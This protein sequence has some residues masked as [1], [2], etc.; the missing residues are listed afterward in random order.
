LKFI[1]DALTPDLVLTTN[2]IIN[3][4]VLDEGKQLGLL[5]KEMIESRAQLERLIDEGHKLNERERFE[6]PIDLSFL[7]MSTMKDSCSQIKK[8]MQHQDE[9]KRKQEQARLQAEMEEEEIREDE[10]LLQEAGDLSYKVPARNWETPVAQD[11]SPQ[12]VDRSGQRLEAKTTEQR[13]TRYM[14]AEPDDKGIVKVYIDDPDV[15]N[16]SKDLISVS[17]SMKTYMVRVNTSPAL[18][19]GPVEC[20]VIDPEASSW[21]LSKGKRLTLSLVLSEAGRL[22]FQQQKRWEEIQAKM[23]AEKERRKEAGED[24]AAPPA[25]RGEPAAPEGPPPMMPVETDSAP[26]RSLLISC[27]VALLA[28]LVGLWLS[29]RR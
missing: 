13:I 2:L 10:Q 11:S 6:P 20:G 29:T 25:P 14:T 4:K 7:N 17:F 1:M 24:L 27:L 16:A 9:E 3:D 18:I 5:G 28:V 22:N 8:Q 26:S 21:R 23:K 12:I 15:A 19:L